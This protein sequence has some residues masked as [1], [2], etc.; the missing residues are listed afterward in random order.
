VERKEINS[1]IQVEFLS[2]ESVVFDSIFLGDMMEHET[3]MGVL[4]KYNII[5]HN[6][7]AVV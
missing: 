4:I 7:S 3:N 1:K 5:T 6:Q 2:L